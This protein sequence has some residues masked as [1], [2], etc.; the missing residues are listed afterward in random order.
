MESDSLTSRFTIG[1]EIA[2]FLVS[3]GLVPKVWEESLRASNV[4]SFTVN[5]SEDVAYVTF[6]SFQRLEDFIVNDNKCGEGNI[7]T[8]HGVFSGCLNGNDEK[9]AL[10]HPGA[11]TLF[12]HIMEKTDFQAKLQVYTDSKQKKLKPIIFV[13][14]SLGGAVATLATLWVLGKRLRQSSPFCITFGCPLVGDERL[15]EAV[16]REN[17]GGNFCHVVSKHDIV[18][19]MLLAPFE[20]IANPFTTVFGYW[21]GKNVPDSLIQDASRT[22][23]NHVLVS[24]SSPYRPFGTYMFCSSNGAACIEN[25]Q[26]VLEMLH[27]TMQSQ[28]T[29]FEEIAQAC[30]LEHIRYD[31]VLEEGRQNSIRGI[32]IAKS[33]SESSYEI[34]ISSQLEA[35][36]VGAQND[37]AQSALLKA[38]ELEN[39]YNEN[40]E[41]LAIKLSV[42]QSSMAELE[43][44]KER[45]EKE[46]GS[47]YYDSFKKQDMKDIHA[48]LVRVKLAEFWDEI[49]EKWG[50]HELPSD[51]QSQNKWIN[52]GNTY[53]R[54]VE[55]LDIAHYYLTT[56]TNKS[57][58]SD[59][60]PNRHKVLQ[61]W[62]EAKEKTRSSRRQ[63]T[64]TKPASL[65]ENSCF[66]ASVEEAVKDLNNLNN[67]QIQKLQSLE[68]F[69]RDVTTMVNA[70]S[71]ASDVFLE[72][73]SF[74]MWWE[75]W[76]EYNQKQ[77]PGWRS[78]LYEIMEN[79]SWKG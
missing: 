78:S 74:M 72:G 25:A 1:Q 75:D 47:T 57:Y 15:V 43:W 3:C 70:L 71:I 18:P 59:G 30:I 45:C 19:R 41:T 11:L 28:H 2:T 42:R 62:M 7:Q 67:G 22:L 23:L 36:G 21:Q 13:G 50:G 63:R 64:R 10:I 5:E 60:R 34:G 51:F 9:P 53:R 14:H 29:S 38:G 35:I 12:L 44:Y 54:L 24:P 46:D 76:K 69:E 33:N 49:M 26:T 31:S 66:W 48:N 73:S 55:P 4:E 40:V 61:E 16:G 58:F 17:W 39:E 37:H 68:K 56:K 79:E 6:P 65:T 8:D 20:S 32:R 77:S 52:A 27:L